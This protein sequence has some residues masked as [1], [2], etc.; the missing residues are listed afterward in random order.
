M[1]FLLM[2]ATASAQVTDIK[3]KGISDSAKEGDTLKLPLILSTEGISGESILQ[4]IC[5]FFLPQVPHQ[6]PLIQERCCG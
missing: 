5:L 2:L 4:K 6:L 1:G 3:L